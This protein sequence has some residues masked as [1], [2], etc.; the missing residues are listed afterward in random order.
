MIQK[1]TKLRVSDNSDAR[2][3]QCIHPNTKRQRFKK[4]SL[5]NFVK[6]TIKQRVSRRNNIKKKINWVLVG[7][8]KRKINRASGESIKFKSA[9]ITIL[10]DKKNKIMG[11]QIKGVLPRELGNKGLN[12]IIAKARRLV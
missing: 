9:K 6:V 12:E 10:D 8:T 11:S 5:A 4:T 1:E 7:A 3:V 2:V